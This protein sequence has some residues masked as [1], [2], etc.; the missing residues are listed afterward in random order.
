[1]LLEE[2]GSAASPG[3]QRGRGS[4]AAGDERD[5]EKYTQRA[6]LDEKN[7]RTGAAIGLEERKLKHQRYH[8]HKDMPPRASLDL[9]SL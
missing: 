6:L 5:S 3:Q 7:A 9:T 2:P 8:D 4:N 1:M